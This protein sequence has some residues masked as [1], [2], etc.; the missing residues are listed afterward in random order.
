[1]LVSSHQLHLHAYSRQS[2]WSFTMNGSSSQSV[3]ENSAARSGG[4][5]PFERTPGGPIRTHSPQLEQRNRLQPADSLYSHGSDGSRP[6]PPTN[7][8]PTGQYRSSLMA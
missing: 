1:M 5:P 7:L 3:A 2:R 6:P 4:A 8:P